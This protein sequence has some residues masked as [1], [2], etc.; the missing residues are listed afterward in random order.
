MFESPNPNATESAR[1]GY[2]VKRYPRY[3]ETFIVNE[4]LAHEAVGLPIEIY[5]IRPP[6]DTH[7]QDLISQVRAPVHYLP[8]GVTKASDFWERLSAFS[9]RH[10]SIGS[11][12]SLLLNHAPAD[13]VS[14][15]ALAEHAI[16]AAIT[17]FHAHFATSAA[18]VA[19]IAHQLTGIPFTLTAHAKDI[20][21]EDVDQPKLARKIAASKATITVSDFNVKYLKQRMGTVADCVERIYNGLD[22]DRFSYESPQDREP[23]IL[24]VGR[25]VEKKGFDVLIDACAILVERGL[26]FH[27]H[28]IGDGPLANSLREQVS[29][30]GINRHIVFLGPQP[31][32]VVKESLRSAAVFAAPCVEGTDGNRDGLPTVLLE[33]MALGTPCVSTPVTGI[34]EAILH[35]QT[36]LLVPQRDPLAL[37]DALQRLLLDSKVRDDL[38]TAARRHVEANFDIQRNAAIERRLFH[39]DTDSLAVREQLVDAAVVA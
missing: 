6:V 14:A 28:L 39:S 12:C 24:S 8:T 36:G 31:Q 35:E 17:H 22:L 20:F 38:A 10:P 15:I 9:L 2:I 19:W 37:A 30:L 32:D 4:I 27:A 29:R 33:S 16:E 1:V 11:R 25:F 5:S 21:H 3:S 23:A 26:N 13:V 34:P 18:D 7:F